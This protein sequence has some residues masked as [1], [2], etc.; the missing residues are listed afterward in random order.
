MIEGPSTR[1]DLPNVAGLR[2]QAGTVGAVALFGV[3]V[4]HT[5]TN[6]VAFALAGWDGSWPLF[7]LFNPGLS[8]VLIAI[9]VVVWRDVRQCRPRWPARV[10][11]GP[12]ALFCTVKLINVLRVDPAA[13][14]IPIGPGPWVLVG[15]PA[16]L[17]AALP[18]GGSRTHR[19]PDPATADVSG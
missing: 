12:G 17:A 3:G 19:E 5:V 6:T 4:V 11:M 8:A 7:L 15:A 9:A 14:W 13:I 16:L 2:R 1:I 18:A 10:V